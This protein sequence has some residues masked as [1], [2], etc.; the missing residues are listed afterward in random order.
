MLTDL[1]YRMRALLWR[2]AVEGELDDE[3]RFHVERQIEKYMGQGM[4]REEAQRRTRLD[5]GGLEQVKEECRDARGLR[6]IETLWYDFRF[7]WRMLRRSPGFTVVALLTLALGIGANTAIF[8]VVNAVLLR[9]FAYPHSDRLVGLSE[10]E[11][12]LPLMYISMPDLDDW[13]ARNTVFESLEGFRGANAALTGQGDPQRLEIRQVSAG[14]FPMLGIRP[15]LGRP[16]TADDDRPDARPVVLLSDSF[17]AREFGS[18]RAILYKQLMLDGRAYTVIGVIPSSQCHM[19]WR[20]TDAFTPLGLMAGIIGGPEHRDRHAGVWAYGR[21]KPDV[22]LAQARA[23]MESIQSQ[24]DQRYPK[25]NAGLG[26]NVKPLLQDLVRDAQRPLLLLTVA[27]TMVLLIACANLANLLMSRALVRRRELAVRVALGA[28][29]GRLARQHLC[30]SILLAVLGGAAGLG[31][32]YVATFSLGRLAASSFPRIEDVS[33]D[34][35]V[36]LFTL[37]VSLLAGIVFGVF[38]ALTALRVNPDR[39]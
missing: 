22:T 28:G 21:M 23:E 4:T 6:F 8:S 30:E 20:H 27:V 5:F 12:G 10:S 24:L 11:P 16:F 31:V 38:P 34:G 2:G 15:I 18:D 33:I 39:F 35:T 26:V 25:T 9:P 13:R 3:L 14:F 1:W 29:A 32:A 19:T 37:G 7:A 36:L 17:W